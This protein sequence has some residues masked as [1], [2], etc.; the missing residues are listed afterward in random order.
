MQFGWN[1]TNPSTP[2]I[3]LS[4]NEL[5]VDAVAELNALQNS[6]GYI[7][8][9]YAL[10]VYSESSI[11]LS[12][13]TPESLKSILPKWGVSSDHKLWKT[14]IERKDTTMVSFLTR[15]YNEVPREEGK[16]PASVQ[17]YVKGICDR[18]V[19]SNSGESLVANCL[20]IMSNGLET[21][22]DRM[23]ISLIHISLLT[24]VDDANAKKD[25]ESK[26]KFEK[27]IEVMLRVTQF[28]E[29]VND[30]KII[31][32]EEK[33]S[34]KE[35]S[36][37][38]PEGV[39][40]ECMDELVSVDNLSKDER[41]LLVTMLKSTGANVR[42]YSV[43]DQVEDTLVLLNMLKEKGLSTFEP[44][45]MRWGSCITMEN[46]KDA[47]LNFLFS[48]DDTPMEIDSSN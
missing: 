41:M 24:Q 20:D 16:I 39:R 31:Y 23:G 18:L 12:E 33:R 35:L 38:Y 5:T 37:L 3:I 45:N 25:I 15:L 42:G 28:V 44:V 7:G 36:S 48:L 2:D 43:G 46:C 10:S 22:I 32:D 27:E 40:V 29:D 47:S 17:S 21:C 8:P 34:F 19:K 6:V 26:N 14:L 1:A 30:Y 9:R 11:S 13:I 4:N